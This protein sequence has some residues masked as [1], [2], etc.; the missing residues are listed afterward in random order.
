MN[1]FSQA[2]IDVDTTQSTEYQSSD[3]GCLRKTD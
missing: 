1:V 2:N 3:T